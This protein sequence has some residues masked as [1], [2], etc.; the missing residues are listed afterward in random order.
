MLVATVQ[1]AIAPNGAISAERVVRSS[2][3]AGF[4]ESVLRA[5]RQAD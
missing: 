1:F 4:D 2:G 3:N 5:I